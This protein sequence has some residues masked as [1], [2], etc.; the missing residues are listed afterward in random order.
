MQALQE[1]APQVS[2]TERRL[3]PR[4]KVAVPTE[5]RVKGRDVPVRV[6]TSDLSVGGCYVEMMFT[7]ELGTK[8]EMTMWIGDSKVKTEGM[9]V[10]R[11]LQFGNGIEFTTISTADQLVLSRFLDDVTAEKIQ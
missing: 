3:W 4:T 5:L 7:F 10:T 2:V 8:L 6:Q 9:V 1:I 11:H